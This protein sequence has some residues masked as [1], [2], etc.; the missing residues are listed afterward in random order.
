MKHAAFVIQVIHQTKHC[1][2][3]TSQAE[4]LISMAALVWM[5]EEGLMPCTGCKGP[6][7]RVLWCVRGCPGYVRTGIVKP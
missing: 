6:D 7:R 3:C 4:K 5:S 2:L 1:M